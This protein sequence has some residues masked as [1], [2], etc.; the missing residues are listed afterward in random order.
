MQRTRSG[1]GPSDGAL[2]RSAR[3]GERWAQEALY[4]R[5]VPMVD[6]LAFRLAGDHSEADD[7]VQDAFVAALDGLERLAEPEAFRGWLK[8]I[9]VRTAAKRLRRRGLRRRLGLLRSAPVE[10]AALISEGAPP[11][12]SAELRRIYRTIDSFPAQ[13]RIALILRRIEGATIA[14]IADQL[15]VSEPTVKRRLKQAD[16]LLARHDAAERRSR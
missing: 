8:A 5:Y 15:G 10:P 6:A 2:V 11:D 3:A 9:V 7:L 14:E 16:R 1:S 12:V 13:V 4:R